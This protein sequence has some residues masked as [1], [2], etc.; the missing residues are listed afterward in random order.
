MAAW[1]LNSFFVK[2]IDDNEHAWLTIFEWPAQIIK[3]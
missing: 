3:H 1:L 2:L